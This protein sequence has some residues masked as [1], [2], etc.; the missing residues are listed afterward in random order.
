MVANCL[1]CSE[2]FSAKTL[3]APVI[4]VVIPV[5][6]FFTQQTQT[7]VCQSVCNSAVSIPLQNILTT[8]PPGVRNPS[9][10]LHVYRH[11]FLGVKWPGH[12]AARSYSF[13]VEVKI[14]RSCNTTLSLQGFMPWT[15]KNLPPVQCDRPKEH[16]AAACTTTHQLNFATKPTSSPLAPF[17]RRSIHGR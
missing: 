4:F 6:A 10:Q 2:S 14:E 8:P 13:G 12:E 5:L 17:L 16:K 7:A 9:L 1:P 11:P 3:Y 15:G